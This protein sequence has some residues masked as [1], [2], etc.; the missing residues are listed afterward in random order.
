M[1]RALDGMEMSRWD[2]FGTEYDR[3]MQG[4]KFDAKPSW[5]IFTM[6]S[7]YL[8]GKMKYEMAEDVFTDLAHTV[9]SFKGLD[10]DV[11]G[12]S[13]VQIKIKQTV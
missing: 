2:K 6:L 3:W 7:A 12:E 10:Y 1:D 9:D 8:G 5:K 13:G 4:S 11:L